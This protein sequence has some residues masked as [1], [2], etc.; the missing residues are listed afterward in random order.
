MA[1]RELRQIK[2]LS[3]LG[4]NM[5]TLKSAVANKLARRATGRAAGVVKKL[6]VQHVIS[7]PSV[8]TGSLRDAIVAKKATKAETGQLTSMHLVAVRV[9]KTGRKTKTHQSTAPHAH[10]V[11]F[12]TVN[13][14]AEPFMRPA[15]DQGKER[16]LQTVIDTLSDGIDKEAAALRK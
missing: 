8:E 6:A 15:F 4:E 3:Q 9:R 2:G 12:G 5:R 7:S 13:M 1:T 11:E 16:A 10:F 14:P